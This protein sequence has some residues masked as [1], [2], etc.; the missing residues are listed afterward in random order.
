MSASC[1]ACAQDRRRGLLRDETVCRR[2]RSK[3]L[4]W[5]ERAPGYFADE[6]KAEL[7]RAGQ[8]WWPRAGAV[9]SPDGRKIGKDYR[10]TG[11]ALS[12]MTPTQIC[13]ELARQSRRLA[14]HDESCD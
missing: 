9:V 3:A 14:S 4:Q 11:P 13:A 2:V 6:L 1:N 5:W 8:E 10:K 7:R 12:E